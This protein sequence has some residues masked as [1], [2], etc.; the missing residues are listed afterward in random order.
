MDKKILIFVDYREKESGVFHHLQ[1][2]DALIKLV[3]LDVGD[4]VCSDR[5]VVERKNFDDFAASIVDGRIFEQAKNLKESYEKPII[6]VEGNCTHRDISKNALK[7]TLASLIVDFEIPVLNTRNERDTADM[8]YW[9]AKREQMIKNIDVGIRRKNKKP[10]EIKKMQEYILCGLPN[11]SNVLAKRL[12]NKFGSI[13]AIFC[14]SQIEL[15]KVK[16]LGK[17]KAKIIFDVVNANSRG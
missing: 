12:L 13:R 2:T 3:N 1:N 4:Y 14:A 9:L 10:T 11:V 16:G 7:A 8:V 5:S 15:E 17:K 6:I